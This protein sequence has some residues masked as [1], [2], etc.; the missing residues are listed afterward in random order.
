M[1]YQGGEDTGGR[2]VY[3][4]NINYD[5]KEDELRSE[6]G[7]VSPRIFLLLPHHHRS[8]RSCFSPALASARSLGASPLSPT[9]KVSHSSTTKTRATRR[10]ASPSPCPRPLLNSRPGLPFAHNSRPAAPSRS[11]C[12]SLP[13]DAISKMNGRTL[14]GR[15]LNVELSKDARTLAEQEKGPMMPPSPGRDDPGPRS[16]HPSGGR[17]AGTSSVPTRNLFVANIPD[18][19]DERAVQDYFSRCA[20]PRRDPPDPRARQIACSI[21]PSAS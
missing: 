15:R 21:G 4:G 19:M 1:P 11:P 7:E 10:R 9:S 12:H 18:S 17:N 14:F 3:I 20:S 13:Q 6:F 8:A 5:F 2:R 16:P